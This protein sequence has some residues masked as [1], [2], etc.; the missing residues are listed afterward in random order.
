MH[1]SS[2]VAMAHCG[3]AVTQVTT[4]PHWAA[5]SMEPPYKDRAQENRTGQ[6]R[7]QTEQ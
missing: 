4:C 7:T 2:I 1:G 6:D 5:I 3:Q